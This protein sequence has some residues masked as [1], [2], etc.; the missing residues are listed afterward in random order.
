MKREY[1]NC[2]ICGTKVKNTSHNNRQKYCKNCAKKVIK[3][4]DKQRRSVNSEKIK[5]E[6]RIWRSQNKDKT[7]DYDRK[8][9]RKNFEK[10]IEKS[11]AYYQSHKE[12]CKLQHEE[13]R[14]KNL[15][16]SKRKNR[17]YSKKHTVENKAHYSKAHNNKYFNGNRLKALK[18]DN[19]ICQICKSKKSLIVHHRDED[20]NIENRNN[21]LDNLVTLCR[22]C[23]FTIHHLSG[24]LRKIN[25][26]KKISYEEIIEK[27]IYLRRT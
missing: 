6:M 7:K 11:R 26:I 5:R 24:I 9:Y 21:N 13:W 18:K 3:E 1:I 14:Q 17:E 16:K 8:Y 4:K 12:K 27:H 10:L 22:S 25:K 19:N 23:H 2:E 20:N 15:E